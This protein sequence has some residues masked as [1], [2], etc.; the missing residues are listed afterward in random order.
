M[1]K[2]FKKIV[3]GIASFIVSGLLVIWL[4]SDLDRSQVSQLWDQAD[5]GYLALAAALTCLVPFC[6]VIRWLGVLRSQGFHLMFT[7]ALRAVLMANVV[8]SFVP[9]KAGE[10]VKVAYLRRQAG[11]VQGFGTIILER[12]IDLAMLGLLGLIAFILTGVQWGLFAAMILLGGV[13]TVFACALLIPTQKLPLPA[14]LRSKFSDLAAVF[15]IWLKH[16]GAM[17]QTLAGSFCVWSIAGFTVACLCFAFNLPI[18][19]ALAYAVYPLAVLAGLL[20]LTISGIGT[21]ESAFIFLLTQFDVTRD[22]AT[23]V[24]FGYTFYAYWF[25]SLISLPAVGW[26]IV[27][28]LKHKEPAPSDASELSNS[29]DTPD[30]P[31][32]P[33]TDPPTTPAITELPRTAGFRHSPDQASTPSSRQF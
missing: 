13:S 21:R 4:L 9:S 33:V 6:G 25:L 12:L 15:P 14:K 3:L 29:A 26:Q 10:V 31:A 23:L 20:P 30:A 19:W 22:Q 8:N 28:I 11:L 32:A 5:K 16:P 7:V 18:N 27:S 24:A 1:K 17:L 2:H